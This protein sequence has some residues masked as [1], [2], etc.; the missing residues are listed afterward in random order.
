M[1]RLL[2]AAALSVVAAATI[3]AQRISGTVTDSLGNAIAQASVMEV[4]AN[5]RILS[6]AKTDA[7]GNFNLTL[8]NAGKTRLYINADGFAMFTQRSQKGQLQKFIMQ[9][10]TIS[11]LAKVWST[12]T[13]KTQNYVLTNKLFCGHNASETPIPWM[14]MLE[15]IGDSTYVLRVPVKAS[16][17]NS[18]YKEGR[19]LTFVDWADGQ[20]LTAF[21]GEDASAIKGNPSQRS[22]WKNVA[23]SEHE[24]FEIRHGHADDIIDEELYF[25][26][27]FMLTHS[28][29]QQ[30][31]KEAD[32]IGRLLIDTEQADNCWNMYLRSNFG[33]ELQKVL[34]KLHENA[35]K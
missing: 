7:N 27:A 8:R 17:I 5:H 18:V 1:R 23:T 10:R 6:N 35:V 13:N 4:D 12:C 25:Y 2:C 14:S 31:I 24:T 30:L 34:K 19:C 3:S 9:K 26:P 20:L 16:H 29:M 32:H 33:K 11:R 15:L 28:E 21:N 22:T